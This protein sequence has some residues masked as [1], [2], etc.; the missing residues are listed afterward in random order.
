MAPLSKEN[1]PKIL[2]YFPYSIIQKSNFSHAEKKGKI[3][4]IKRNTFFNISD[5]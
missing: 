4:L 1:F 2:A 3:P 5:D